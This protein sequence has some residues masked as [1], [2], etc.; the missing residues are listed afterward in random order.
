[1]TTL[2]LNNLYMQRRHSSQWIDEEQQDNRFNRAHENTL[3]K[4]YAGCKTDPCSCV[5]R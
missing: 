3:D 4:I 2:N 1:M 5:R